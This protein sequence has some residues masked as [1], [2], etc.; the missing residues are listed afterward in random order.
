M[1]WNF[2]IG[3]VNFLDERE[4]ER[5]ETKNLTDMYTRVHFSNEYVL[6]IYHVEHVYVQMVSRFSIGMVAKL[7]HDV[8]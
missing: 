1:V 8:L 7:L 5:G 3:L 2:L 4:R 6:K